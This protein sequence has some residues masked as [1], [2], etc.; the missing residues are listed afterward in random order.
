MI[1]MYVQ[2]VRLQPRVFLIGESCS[3]CSRSVNCTVTFLLRTAFI[4][5]P[6]PFSLVVPLYS[7]V[8]AVS[9]A[10][11][12]VSTAYLCFSMQDAKS[13]VPAVPVMQ[14]LAL[15]AAC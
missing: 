3:L 9:I 14:S 11:R 5:R 4:L 13:A 2:C 15:A 1:N 6:T 7:T 8:V 10:S 12:S